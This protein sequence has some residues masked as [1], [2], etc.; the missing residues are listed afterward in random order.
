MDKEREIRICK[1]QIDDCNRYEDDALEQLK[2]TRKSRA[3]Y[4]DRL[5]KLQKD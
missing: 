2:I 3:Y 4:Q 5:E 1:R